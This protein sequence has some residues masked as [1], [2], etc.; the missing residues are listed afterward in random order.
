[1]SLYS[2]EEP[3]DVDL[4][5]LPRPTFSEVALGGA[6]LLV[7]LGLHIGAMFPPYPG[8]PPSSVAS[9][10][11]EIAV[12]VC[13][14]VG[15]ALA[16]FLVLSRVSVPG[17]A[18]LGAGLGVVELGLLGVDITNG[19]EVSNGSQAGAWLALAGIGFGAAGVLVS[20]STVRLGIP[21]PPQR[22]PALLMLLATFAV[23]L[24]YLP[25]WDRW[26]A[27]APSVHVSISVTEG[28]AF[29][30]PAVV[31]ACILFSVGAFAFV[32]ILGSVW[33]PAAVGV[34]A[35]LG[36]VIALASQLISAVFQLN[37]AVPPTVFG[38]TS[39]Q[40]RAV[41]LKTSS[42]LT[43]WWAADVVAVV[44]L[45]LVA[46]WTVRRAE[47]AATAGGDL[48]G[49]ADEASLAGPRDEWPSEHHWPRP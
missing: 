29:S 25:S 24:A 6:L 44:A 36:A 5:G 45:A 13:F 32:T 31:M 3:D 40:A 2:P 9:S 30:D 12:Y 41:G 18:A 27:V 39:A 33:Y 35:I 28:N 8:L 49:A 1:M 4:A 16:A 48:P 34:W 7:C 15:W 47:Q 14:E 21:R 43:G 11:W 26:S 10:S 46:L 23:V 42:S 20:A 38:V 19:F 37:E 22:A 17:G